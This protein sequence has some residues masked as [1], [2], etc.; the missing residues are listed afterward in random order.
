MFD[1]MAFVRGRRIA[2]SERGQRPLDTSAREISTSA[3]GL[4]GV[5]PVLGR[6]FMPADES[7]GAA[8]VAIIAYRFW[9]NRFNKRSD[10]VGLTVEINRAPA[11]IIGVMPD[12]FDFPEQQN[13]WMP[14]LHSPELEQRGPGGYMAFGRLRDGVSLQEARAELRTISSCLEAEYPA[15]NHGVFPRV[16]TH[17]EFFI[18]P[19][20]PIIY[21]SLWAGAWFVLLIVCANL[22]NLALARTIGQS[23]EL[24]TRIALGAGQARMIRQ[25][26]VESLLLSGIGGTL[27]WWIAKWACE[28]G[29]RPQH[30]V[31]RYST[32]RWIPVRSLTLLDSLPGRRFSF[33]WSR[34]SGPGSFG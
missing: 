5:S 7:P 22:A 32:T 3:F 33:R 27:G 21:G 14:L 2:F 23:H 28:P 10:I 20:A 13:I 19:D 6:D 26:L 9:E 31:S 18:G 30:H 11:T 8:P 15:T 24:S 4:L 12:G 16:N 25:I 17:A 1:G 34:S 29:P